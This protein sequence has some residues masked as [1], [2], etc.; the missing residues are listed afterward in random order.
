[1]QDKY[2]IR[3]FMEIVS[4]NDKT[5]YSGTAIV[6]CEINNCYRKRQHWTNIRRTF[7]LGISSRRSVTLSI[8]FG[9]NFENRAE[10]YRE[11]ED[12]REIWR[13]KNFLAILRNI[14]VGNGSIDLIPKPVVN[15]YFQQFTDRWGRSLSGMVGENMD[16]W[17][18]HGEAARHISSQNETLVRL[19]KNL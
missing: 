15:P 17:I 10:R 8:N 7:I 13:R 5:C 12:I 9:S 1:M 2:M 4:R 19:L 11:A 18:W 3:W 16:G 14:M 6:H